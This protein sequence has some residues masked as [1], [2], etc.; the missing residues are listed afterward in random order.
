M[1]INFE[2]RQHRLMPKICKPVPL[3]ISM[4]SLQK[5]FIYPFPPKINPFKNMDLAKIILR[6]KIKLG[7]CKSETSACK[8]ETSACKS[9]T[10]ACKSETSACKSETSACK[11]ET[12][13]C[14]SETSACK[15]I[16]GTYYINH[17]TKCN[18]QWCPLLIV[19]SCCYA[20]QY[21]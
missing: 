3:D 18:T 5:S 19:Q 17:G 8:S 10:C 15:A 6:T 7:D 16:F 2:T 9:E 4:W 1:M 21:I 12:S 13:A 14:K 20:M 11:S